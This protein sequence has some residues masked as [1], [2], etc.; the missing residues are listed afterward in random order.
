MNAT[1]LRDLIRRVLKEANLIKY[2]DEREVE[3]LMLTAATESNL[4][5]FIR[6]KGGPALGIYQMEPLTHQD[7]HSNFLVYKNLG[8]PWN[9]A[10][11]LEYDLKYATLMAR[12]HYLRV[13]EVIPPACD[14]SALASYW[15]QTWNTSKGKGTVAKAIEK[16]EK[17]CL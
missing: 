9:K 3:L 5:Y 10:K 4:G 17:Y 11:Q 14:I 13:K 2:E 8:I 7:I 6:Q 1:Q 15:K 12:A 16:Y